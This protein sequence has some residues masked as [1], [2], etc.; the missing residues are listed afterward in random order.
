MAAITG[1]PKPVDFV[2]G[3]WHEILCGEG[4]VTVEDVQ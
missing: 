3:R 4:D 1:P 2:D